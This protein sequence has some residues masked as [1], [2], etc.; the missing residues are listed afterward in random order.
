[1]GQIRFFTTVALPVERAFDYLTDPANATDVFRGMKELRQLSPGS[2]KQ[3]SRLLAIRDAFDEEFTVADY[4]PP[5]SYV[6]EGGISRLTTRLGYQLEPTDSGTRIGILFAWRLHGPWRAIGPL[7][8]RRV[9]KEYR[10]TLSHVADRLGAI[11]GDRKPPFEAQ[12]D[13]M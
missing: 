2:L 9:S 13:R 12:P 10:Q 3:G 1:M 7:F 5:T 4:N 6:L 11:V 8:G